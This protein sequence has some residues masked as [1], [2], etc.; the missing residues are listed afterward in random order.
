MF[1]L[2]HIT[3]LNH[4]D[5]GRVETGDGGWGQLGSGSGGLRNSRP[6][7]NIPL[8]HH[9]HVTSSKRC[10]SMWT[11]SWSPDVSTLTRP[12]W[13]Q[14]GKYKPACACHFISWLVRACFLC[15][16]LNMAFHRRDFAV[17]PPPLRYHRSTLTLSCKQFIF[18]T[19]WVT[20]SRLALDRIQIENDILEE[21]QCKSHSWFVRPRQR[22]KPREC[23]WFF[24]TPYQLAERKLWK[25]IFTPRNYF[26]ASIKLS[27]LQR[28]EA[29]ILM[30]S[31]LCGAYVGQMLHILVFP[32][33]LQ[34]TKENF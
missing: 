23:S 13:K 11:K 12:I 9:K 29:V 22:F 21:G 26:R 32:L 19:H 27:C 15:I 8:S 14:E 28:V 1:Q 3:H 17:L 4:K 20:V 33:E 31:D 34:M 2:F 18:K 6:R 30:N 24:S 16:S 5:R 25:Q 7:S 10:S